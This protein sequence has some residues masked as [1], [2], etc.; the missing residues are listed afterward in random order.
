MEESHT[1]ARWQSPR[2]AT[3]QFQD[4][5]QK[6]VSSYVACEGV[7]EYPLLRNSLWQ[8][9]A[10]PFSEEAV[11]TVGN[12]SQTVEPAVP[13]VPPTLA[14][15]NASRVEKVRLFFS[16]SLFVRLRCFLVL[17]YLVTCTP[18]FST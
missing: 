5:F 16:L 8:Y 2:R 9:V 1:C 6:K 7:P 4:G 17:T 15:E 3:F 12:V 18:V 14:Q 13:V 10:A 11:E